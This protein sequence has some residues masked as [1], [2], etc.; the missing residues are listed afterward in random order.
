MRCTNMLDKIS[1]NSSSL[2]P[3]S[4]CCVSVYG[5]PCAMHTQSQYF[6]IIILVFSNF[7]LELYSLPHCG[8]YLS[9]AIKD[10][11]A[12]SG[13]SIIGSKLEIELK[14]ELVN[15]ERKM[16]IYVQVYPI[17]KFHI[18]HLMPQIIRLFAREKWTPHEQRNSL[19]T[20][21]SLQYW[22]LGSA[23]PIYC[24]LFRLQKSIVQMHLHSRVENG[25]RTALT[26]FRS[27]MRIS[28]WLLNVLR[29]D[30]HAHV[31]RR[32]YDLWRSEFSCVIRAKGERKKK[33][34]ARFRSEI[35]DEVM[36]SSAACY[37]FHSRFRK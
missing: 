12:A 37:N 2:A 14:L 11:V 35:F 8:S 1:K 3:F 27:L 25:K 20:R 13:N 7:H 36:L 34:R 26:R 29:R 33:K 31:L 24:E 5:A 18:S 32:Y 9:S 6:I 16:Y 23:V 28:C 22:P 21:N 17:P 30:G 15:A 19:L 10:G 4:V